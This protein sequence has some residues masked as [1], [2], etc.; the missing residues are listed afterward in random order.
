MKKKITKK[1]KPVKQKIDVV[2]ESL[3]NLERKVKELIDRVE[4]LHKQVYYHPEKAVPKNPP[5]YPQLD[6]QQKYWPNTE[7]PFKYKGIMWNYND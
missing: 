1:K 4:S 5:L 7:P 2:L 6:P 3:L